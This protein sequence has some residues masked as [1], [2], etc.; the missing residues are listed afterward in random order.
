M[1]NQIMTHKALT[2]KQAAQCNA[3]MRRGNPIIHKWHEAVAEAR[4]S[5]EYTR[6]DFRTELFR[7]R[8][9]GGSHV[10]LF[11][12]PG[13]TRAGNVR[14]IRIP[15]RDVE[16]MRAVMNIQDVNANYG[17]KSNDG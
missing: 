12:L 3:T 7:H 17:Y 13:T 4:D 11:Q 2:K 15:A 10:A 8:N 6:S 9:A 5:K 16:L 14:T 1:N